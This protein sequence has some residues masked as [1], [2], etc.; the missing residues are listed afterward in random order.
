MGLLLGNAEFVVFKHILIVNA[1]SQSRL[2]FVKQ[3]LIFEKVFEK[4]LENKILIQKFT[5]ANIKVFI[6]KEN[7]VPTCETNMYLS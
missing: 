4:D 3:L 5:L 1:N 6:L 2:L 7:T